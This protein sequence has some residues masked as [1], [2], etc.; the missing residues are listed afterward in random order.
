MTEADYQAACA[1]SREK[2]FVSTGLIQRHLGVGFNA[3]ARVVEW[4]EERGFCTRADFQGRRTL[5]Q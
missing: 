5:I 3:A 2:G 1:F 4:M